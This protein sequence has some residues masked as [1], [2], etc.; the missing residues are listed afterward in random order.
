M[1]HWRFTRRAGLVALASGY[2][3]FS[4]CEEKEADY[5]DNEKEKRK[6]KEKPPLPP[7]GNKMRYYDEKSRNYWWYEKQSGEAYWENIDFNPPIVASDSWDDNWDNLQHKPNKNKAV[8]QIILIRHGQYDTSVKDDHKRV[9]TELGVRQA[10]ACGKQ[11]RRLIDAGRIKPID[12]IFYSTMTRATQTYNLIYPSLPP[13]PPHKCL[14][15]SMIRE[16]PVAKTIPEFSA[17]AKSGGPSDESVTLAGS[18]VEAAFKNYFHRAH[19]N[20]E[21][22]YSTV[23]ICHANVIRYFIAR[24]L[25]LPPTSWS[26]YSLAHTGIVVLEIYPSGKVALL[27][28]DTGHCEPEMITH[29]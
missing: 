17:W 22:S 20:V 4:S 5:K 24:A 1:I 21:K 13:M 26:R 8:H 28:G 6:S 25:Q 2:F 29:S 10:E 15:C 18:R 14:P 12:Q 19:E 27:L 7:A 23:L 3:H 11:L 16:G 9:L